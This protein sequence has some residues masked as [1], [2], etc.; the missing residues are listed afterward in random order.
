L[1][2]AAGKQQIEFRR[3]ADEAGQHG[4]DL[5]AVVG[6]VIEP[7]RQRRR[8]IEWPTRSGGIQPATTSGGPWVPAK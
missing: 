8:S 7:V 6:L 4:V 3:L 5:A 1:P 2:A